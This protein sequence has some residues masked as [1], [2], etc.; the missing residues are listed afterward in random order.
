MMYILKHFLSI[1]K[2]EMVLVRL[3][4]Q[5]QYCLHSHYLPPSDNKA[6]R[7]GRYFTNAFLSSSVSSFPEG[8]L[9]TLYQ[10]N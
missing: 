6:I 2:S 10:L 5:R 1:F 9:P 7:S 3:E 4:I 8:A